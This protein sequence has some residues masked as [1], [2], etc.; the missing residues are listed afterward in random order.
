MLVTYCDGC[1]VL[2]RHPKAEVRVHCPACYERRKAM[3]T[4]VVPE[5]LPY[6]ERMNDFGEDPIVQQAQKQFS[7]RKRGVKTA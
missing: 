2:V 6:A 3:A 7:G 1:G 5:A 4:R